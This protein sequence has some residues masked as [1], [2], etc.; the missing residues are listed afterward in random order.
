MSVHVIHVCTKYHVRFLSHRIVLF[1]ERKGAS[2]NG[3]R[4]SRAGKE[5]GKWVSERVET[6]RD[7]EKDVEQFELSCSCPWVRYRT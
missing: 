2:E 4:K 3:T 5:E 6:R 1:G 7:R